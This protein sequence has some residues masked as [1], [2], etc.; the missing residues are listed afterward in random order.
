MKLVNVRL[1]DEDAAKAT[2]LRRQGVELSELVRE[3][4]RARHLAL[5]P[6]LRARDVRPMLEAIFA[7]HPLDHEHERPLVDTTDRAAMRSLIRR[8][9]GRRR[10]R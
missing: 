3:A 4:V 5:R 9:L 10:R 1:S 6:V 2:E 7:R 8:K